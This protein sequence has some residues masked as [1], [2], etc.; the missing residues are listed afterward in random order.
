MREKKI[1]SVHEIQ[2]E[3]P[4]DVNKNSSESYIEKQTLSQWL[5]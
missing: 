1:E 3:A 2:E 5:Y 4:R